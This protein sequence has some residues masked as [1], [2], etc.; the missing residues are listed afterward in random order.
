M[1]HP[2]DLQKRHGVRW[3]APEENPFG[4]TAL[5]LRG[6]ALHFTVWSTSRARA[7]EYLIRQ[8]DD[9]EDLRGKAPERA[10]TLQ[11]PPLR[12]AVGAPDPLPEGPL[13]RPK[14]FEDLWFLYHFNG[15]LFLYHWLDHTLVFRA[16]FTW[17]ERELVIGSFDMDPAYL[18]RDRLAKG[19]FPPGLCDSPALYAVRLFDALLK[20]HL[21][22]RVV[23][24]PLPPGLARSRE[25]EQPM[26][27]P[28]LFRRWPD[29]PK[30][31]EDAAAAVLA[32]FGRR[33]L[34]ATFD[35]TLSL[36]WL[37]VDLDS[38][39]ALSSTQVQASGGTP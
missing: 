34:L 20:T 15:A 4:I 22:S 16:P 39:L 33:G 6:V 36:P 35:E 3:L 37:D 21:F 13:F 18:R 14:A 9:G 26:L 27:F 7:E 12:Y 17:D 8:R 2:I 38:F 19:L 28:E 5:D 29:D 31:I 23:P 30:W 25:P 1:R 24:V 32:L 10:V 11:F